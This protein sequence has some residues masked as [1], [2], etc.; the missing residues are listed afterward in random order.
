[1]K[2]TITPRGGKSH[3]SNRKSITVESSSPDVVF[4]G[5]GLRHSPVRPARTSIIDAPRISDEW[6][7]AT[8]QIKNNP[9]INER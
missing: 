8:P 5:M 9:H 3:R 6:I 1:V 2:V 4:G 7:G